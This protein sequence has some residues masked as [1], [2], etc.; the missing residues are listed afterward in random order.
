MTAVL[1]LVEIQGSGIPSKRSARYTADIPV[2]KRPA[3]SCLP[4]HQEG[5]S[6]DVSV[7]IHVFILLFI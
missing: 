7:C 1:D 5:R 6:P 4:V 3:V 2:A